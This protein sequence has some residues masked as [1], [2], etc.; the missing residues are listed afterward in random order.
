MLVEPEFLIKPS[1]DSG[2]GRLITFFSGEIT[3]VVQR[4]DSLEQ[5][6]V[7]EVIQLTSNARHVK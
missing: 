1:I 6:T 3:D 7:Q 4:I 2:E 5:F